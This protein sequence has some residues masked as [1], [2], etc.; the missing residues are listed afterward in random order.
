MCNMVNGETLHEM[1]L[2]RLQIESL[3]LEN[4]QLRKRFP[5]PDPDW[6]EICRK[7]AEGEDVEDL[8][9]C[10]Y[11]GEPNGCNSPIYGEHP[12]ACN[13]NNMRK[14]YVALTRAAWA[15]AS[16]MSGT[17]EG[18]K[19]FREDWPELQEIADSVRRALDAPPRNCDRFDTEEEA[20][21]AFEREEPDDNNLEDDFTGDGALERISRY[22][23]WLFEYA[24]HGKNKK[25]EEHGPEEES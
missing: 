13:M 18:T 20:F 15:I 12:R 24:T 9:D 3:K 4:E 16:L 1:E 7:C 21:E 17:P 19:P 25:G 6:A 2:L 11:Y 5:Q 23:D 14:M 22:R 10:E 8:P